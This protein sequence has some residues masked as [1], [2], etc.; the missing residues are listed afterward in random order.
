MHRLESRQMRQDVRRE[1]EERLGLADRAEGD[2]QVP[3][4]PVGFDHAAGR[5]ESL[6]DSVG[7]TALL[8][9]SRPERVDERVGHGVSE[10]IVNPLWEGG[11]SRLVADPD[12]LER[13]LAAPIVKLDPIHLDSGAVSVWHADRRRLGDVIVDDQVQPN[14]AVAGG[15]RADREVLDPDARVKAA[16]AGVRSRRAAVRRW[17]LREA[18]A[19]AGEVRMGRRQRS[20][21]W[22]E[23]EAR[24]PPLEVV[25]PG[26]EETRVAVQQFSG[27]GQGW[28]G[29]NGAIGGRGLQPAR[30]H[31]QQPPA[32]VSPA[33]ASASW[34][35][36]R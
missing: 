29:Q 20:D 24:R 33:R 1:P 3:D 35:T 5:S 14:A 21:S 18:D 23:D 36:A 8:E 27:F 15:D 31:Q 25:F 22:H 4:P 13:N 11:K 9:R 26:F 28:R 17:R 19:Q 30:V 10:R 16:R 2:L 7:I 32:T 12:L 6:A 34:K